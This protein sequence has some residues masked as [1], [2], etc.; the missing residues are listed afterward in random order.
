MNLM[1]SF[2]LLL[3]ATAISLDGLG[4]GVAYG[5]KGTI[6]PWPARLLVALV[7]TITVTLAFFCG[8]SLHWL[9]PP[10]VAAA[11]GRIILVLAGIYLSFQGWL[12]GKNNADPDGGNLQLASL[13]L[14]R[15]GI[16]ILIMRHPASADLDRSGRISAGEALLLG[17]AL[18]ADAFGAGAGAGALR[19]WPLYTPILVGLSKF[20]FLSAGWSLGRRW[21]KNLLLPWINYLPGFLLVLLGLTG[22]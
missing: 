7:S 9:F 13:P 22:L 15:L 8:G 12:A 16:V 3:L 6:I 5:L 14:K 1:N 2:Y 19:A 20:L 4:A 11:L 21:A 18:A 10:G 17:L